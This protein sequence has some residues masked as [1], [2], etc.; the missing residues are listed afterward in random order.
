MKG[1]KRMVLLVP[2]DR[3][4]NDPDY[5]AR[6]WPNFVMNVTQALQTF[7]CDIRVVARADAPERPTP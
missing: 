1:Q 7:D 6:Y 2:T 5:M 3:D 4:M